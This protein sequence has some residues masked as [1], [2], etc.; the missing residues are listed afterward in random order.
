MMTQKKINL[1]LDLDNTIINSLSPHEVSRINMKKNTLKY[2]TMTKGKSSRDYY[3][4]V[5]ER[6]HLQMFLDYAFDNFHVS[7]W[8][9]ASR[10][11][12]S[13]IIDNIIIQNKPQRKLRMFL[14]DDN[15][16]QSQDLYNENSPKDL[17]YLYHFEGFA[18]CNTII[19]D[20]LKD[21]FN[22]NSKQTIRADYF[23]VK[24]PKSQ[25]DDF[26]LRAI[27]DLKKIKKTFNTRECKVR[28]H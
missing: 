10:P 4:K 12:A 1:V 14:Y 18:P 7:V 17:Q 21:V 6:P 23:D 3:F 25:H 20:D 8:T 15:C 16:E 11:Y 9:A 27:E 2:H 19:M 26:L 24:N 5:F 13:F 22:A 28:H